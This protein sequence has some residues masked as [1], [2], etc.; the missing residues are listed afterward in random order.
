M[1]GPFIIT[2]F[3]NEHIF[4]LFGNGELLNKDR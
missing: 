3:K 4:A 1:E 2:L